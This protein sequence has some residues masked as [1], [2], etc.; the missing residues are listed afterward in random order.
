MFD[1]FKPYTKQLLRQIV[2]TLIDFGVIE[3][4]YPSDI[5]AIISKIHEDD[6]YFVEIDSLL[7]E[8]K[9]RAIYIADYK[10]Y[11]CFPDIPYGRGFRAVPELIVYS[12]SIGTSFFFCP[13][14]ESIKAHYGQDDNLQKLSFTQDGIYYETNFNENA[15]MELTILNLVNEAI[16]KRNPNNPLIYIVFADVVT[17]YILLKPHQFNFLRENKYMRFEAYE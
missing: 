13:E 14:K 12:L 6:Y 3:Y 11:R 5:D 4:L 16:I 17:H 9:S 15:H 1:R 10:E 2:D 8:F 7:L